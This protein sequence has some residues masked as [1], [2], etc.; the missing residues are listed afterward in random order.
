MINVSV[1]GPYEEK[2]EIILLE[3]YDEP[4]FHVSFSS[5]TEWVDVRF[6][7]EVKRAIDVAIDQ[8]RH[9]EAS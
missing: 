3:F 7:E 9:K 1:D 6:L 2:F 5:D 8:C 4:A